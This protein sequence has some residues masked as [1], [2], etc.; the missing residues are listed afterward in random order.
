VV[1]ENRCVHHAEIGAGGRSHRPTA[2]ATSP[3]TG[4]QP[5]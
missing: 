4:L 2:D 3:D 5:S 1:T